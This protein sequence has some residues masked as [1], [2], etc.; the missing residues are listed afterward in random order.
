M[1][2]TLYIPHLRADPVL[3][4]IVDAHGPITL[5]RHNAVG[6]Q[7][8]RSVLGQQLSTKVAR[9]LW[10]RL[11]ALLGAGLP[12]LAGIA[13]L[14][15]E[16]LR[17][18]GLSGAK[19]RYLHNIAAYFEEHN[20]TDERLHAASDEEVMN[21]LLPIVGVGRWT[22]EMLLMFTLGREDVFSPGD[23]GIRQAMAALYNIPATLSKKETD[24]ELL[25]IAE[26]WRPYRTYACMHLWRWKDGDES[27]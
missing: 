13:A 3:C 8:C 1:P 16:A 12:T 11:E 27:L 20:L 2:A 4:P 5:V 19:T 22:V 18:I 17:G 26:A 25:R 9:V 10:S 6:L 7:L 24:A 23:L 21:L 14:P 15:H